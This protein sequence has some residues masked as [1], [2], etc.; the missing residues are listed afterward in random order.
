MNNMTDEQYKEFVLFYR[1]EIGKIFG[2]DMYQDD[3]LDER[4][5]WYE[6][7]WEEAAELAYKFHEYLKQKGL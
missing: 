5:D 4:N 3:G 6:M 7:P 2:D 1:S